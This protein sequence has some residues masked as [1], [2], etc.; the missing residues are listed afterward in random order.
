MHNYIKLANI[1]EQNIRRGTGE[2]SFALENE[3]NRTLV[4]RKNTAL[5]RGSEIS[6]KLLGPM[7]VMLIVA[8]VILM[9][10]AL[11]SINM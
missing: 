8:L 4:E 5:K 9:V 3:L 1:I 6:T 7:T 10:P 11:M 2:L